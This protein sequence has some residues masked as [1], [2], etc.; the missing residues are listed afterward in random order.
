MKP[1]EDERKAYRALIDRLVADCRSGQGQIG[2]GRVRRGIWNE[3]ARADPAS[4]DHRI[5]VLLDRL[6]GE[7]CETVARMLEQEFVAGV[8]AALV[9]LHEHEM[10]PFDEAYEGTPFHDF[11]GRLTEWEWPKNR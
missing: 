6:P 2:P 9:A 5:N 3:H 7:D 11:I 1:E 10:P 4:E 8:H